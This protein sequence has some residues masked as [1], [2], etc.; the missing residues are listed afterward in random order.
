[1]IFWSPEVLILSVTL[2]RFFPFFIPRYPSL[3]LF[4]VLIIWIIVKS[5]VEDDCN[6]GR[7]GIIIVN[8][9]DFQ[10]D[11]EPYA[12]QVSSKDVVLSLRTS[13]SCVVR[14]SNE[15]TP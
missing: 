14:N 4:V 1:M 12:P 9:Y 11:M 7:R 10:K 13:H 2:L 8:I 15:T 5:H 6:G 3:K